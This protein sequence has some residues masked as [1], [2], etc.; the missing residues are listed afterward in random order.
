[1]A[2][3][4][5]PPY[6][7]RVAPDRPTSGE[8]AAQTSGEV[9]IADRLYVPFLKGKQGEIGALRDLGPDA[10]RMVTPAIQV[11]PNRD[12]ARLAREMRQLARAWAGESP[13]LLDTA[14]LDPGVTSRHPLLVAS[15]AARAA[16][17]DLV[18]VVRP[19]SDAAYRSAARQLVA[20]HRQGAAL[21]LPPANWLP[22]NVRPVLD[23]LLQD[24][25]LGPSDA[26]LLLDAGAIAAGA[27]LDLYRSLLDQIMPGLPYLS[28]WRR[29]AIL[30]GAFP[31]DLSSVP[32]GQLERIPRSDWRLWSAFRNFARPIS[33]GDHAVAH[34]D[35]VEEL[36]RPAAIPRYAQLRYSAD[37][38]FV[39]CR[40]GDLNRLGD[41]EMYSLCRRL[42]RAPEWQGRDFS[43]G[44]AWIDDRAQGFGNAGNYSTWRRVGTVH[45]ITK[46]TTQLA[47]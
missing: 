9:E 6:P 3:A 1:M 44:D 2:L 17:L 14:W 32:R 46:V 19:G 28:E 42:V 31:A 33:F 10:R 37:A 39:V 40:A 18:P 15:T 8:T 5:P 4:V 34:P 16:G 41:G 30:S 26:D 35:T 38:D 24:V 47:S 20:R 23:E 29:V 11:F 21:R 22:A 7:H 27:A 45:H 12:D 43:A 25:D 13:V 36:R